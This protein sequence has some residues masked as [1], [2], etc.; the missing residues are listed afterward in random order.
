MKTIRAIIAVMQILLLSGVPAFA[1]FDSGTFR[2]K[3]WNYYDR[4]LEYSESGQLENAISDIS[5]AISSREKDQRMARTYGMHFID[6][7]PHR[8]LGIV[9]FN[10]GDNDR[11]IA[12]LEESVR[13]AES[14]KAVYYLNK[15][16]KVR[17]LRQ[18]GGSVRLPSLTVDSPGDNPVVRGLTAVIKGRASGEGL[19][20]RITF[21]D[22]PYRFELAGEAVSFEDEVQLTDGENTISVRC[23]DLLGNSAEKTV[24]VIVDREGPTINIYDIVQEK[25]P[26]GGRVR[27]TGEVNDNTGIHTVVINGK[28]EKADNTKAYEFD[29]AVPS[30]T[31]TFVIQAS[32]RVDNETRAEIDIR[33]ELAAFSRKPEPILLAFNGN[34]IFSLD[35]EQPVVRLKDTTELPTVFVDKYYVEGEA[36]DNSRVEKI[37]VNNLEVPARQGKKIFFSRTVSLKEGQNRIVVDVYDGSGNKASTNFT[38]TR[39]IPDVLQTN[40]RMSITVMPFDAKQKSPAMAD[41]AYEQLIGSMVSQKRFNV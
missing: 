12:E 11:A 4:G 10:M 3:W 40:S 1:V 35:K 32:D 28:P 36:F 8:E 2:G 21:N 26:E 9:F 18:K 7:F 41:L 13:S 38:V 6:Y 17:I 33:K 23:E 39:N 31:G 15:A 37:M 14:A 16:R 19:I 25:G 24:K 34:K 29:V 27:I 22:R 30:G 20:S 5:K